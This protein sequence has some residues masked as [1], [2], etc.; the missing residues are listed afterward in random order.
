[1][2]EIAR[3][4]S[5][6]C[7]ESAFFKYVNPEKLSEWIEM[8]EENCY[9]HRHLSLLDRLGGYHSINYEKVITQGLSGILAEVE[10]EIKSTT[11]KDDESLNKVTF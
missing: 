3:Y 9:I 7:V 10:Q 6:K 4:W 5:D 2:V 8:S 1:M 11:I